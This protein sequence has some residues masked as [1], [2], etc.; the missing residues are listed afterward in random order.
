[1]VIWTHNRNKQTSTTAG[2][3]RE[4]DNIDYRCITSGF[5]GAKW[6]IDEAEKPF[7]CTSHDGPTRSIS[8]I[9]EFYRVPKYSCL[10][11]L[12]P[13]FIQ[14][15]Y[16]FMFDLKFVLQ[17]QIWLLDIL[18]KWFKHWKMRLLIFF[19]SP[20]FLGSFLLILF[21]NSLWPRQL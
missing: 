17:M 13:I 5:L 20:F 3:A 6:K 12:M 21:D 18:K 16:F 10:F 1:M 2:N 7:F 4:Q 15:L 8:L 14:T 11:R 9:L 19:G